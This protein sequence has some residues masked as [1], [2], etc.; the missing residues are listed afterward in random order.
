MRASIA[1][2]TLDRTARLNFYQIRVD[3]VKGL[4]A[5]RI[6]IC[7]KWS[8]T[9]V[10]SSDDA[11]T[12]SNAN[13]T[14]SRPR[15]GILALSVRDRFPPIALSN[16][17]SFSVPAKSAAPAVDAAARR[18]LWKVYGLWTVIRD[19]TLTGMRQVGAGG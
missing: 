15:S 17:R 6:Q 1:I 3:A 4:L 13:E 8:F 5:N 2:A 9:I 16:V 18:I 14:K 12:V 10:T 11:P 7:G 19:G